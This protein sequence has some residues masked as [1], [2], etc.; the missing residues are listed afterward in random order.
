MATAADGDGDGSAFDR[1]S[2]NGNDAAIAD[3]VP[4]GRTAP[5][6]ATATAAA[7]ETSSG[8]KRNIVQITIRYRP[9]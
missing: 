1:G 9:P 5:F 2:N 7:N 3:D 6:S 8:L 4:H